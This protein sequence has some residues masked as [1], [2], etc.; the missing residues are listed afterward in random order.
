M[1]LRG[2]GQCW[3]SR[4]LRCSQA[5][6][7]SAFQRPTARRGDQDHRGRDSRRPSTLTSTE[8]E[9]GLY[10]LGRRERWHG[11][12]LRH[13]LGDRRQDRRDRRHDRARDHPFGVAVD[14]Q[15]NLV[16]ISEVGGNPATVAPGPVVGGGGGTISVIDGATNTVAEPSTFHPR[17]RPVRNHRSSDRHQ[18]S[19][20]RE[21]SSG[22]IAFDPETGYLWVANTGEIPLD[23]DRCCTVPGVLSVYDT[24][25]KQWL[26]GGAD[27]HPRP[28]SLPSSP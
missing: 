21:R 12:C 1:M 2:A 5:P 17:R 23:P 3:R 18:R 14:Q 22:E 28:G 25:T 7:Y 10:G 13:D 15:A 8:D 26:R 4:S 6:R 11:L 24:N 19:T 16:Y 9:H 20:D 27:G